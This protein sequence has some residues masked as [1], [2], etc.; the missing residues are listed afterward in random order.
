MDPEK[1]FLKLFVI[2]VRNQ[3]T[4]EVYEII[5]NLYPQQELIS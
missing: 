1:K 4:N 3:I 5:K 2:S